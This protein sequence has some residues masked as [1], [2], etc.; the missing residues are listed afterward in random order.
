[1]QSGLRDFNNQSNRKTVFSPVEHEKNQP[2]KHGWCL[3]K[4]GFRKAMRM[5]GGNNLVPWVRALSIHLS[6]EDPGCSDPT[7]VTSFFYYVHLTGTLP[8]FFFF[9]AWNLYLETAQKCCFWLNWAL[10]PQFLSA[11][12]SR[13]L[14]IHLLPSLITKRDT[15]FQHA[16][17]NVSRWLG[18][19]LVLHWP[20]F[21]RYSIITF[22]GN[23][24]LQSFFL[25]RALI[26]SGVDKNTF[27]SLSCW[28]AIVTRCLARWHR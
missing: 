3:R 1:V 22:C 17:R 10:E 4:Y 20:T 21:I 25:D 15:C 18:L 27:C 12:S 6:I 28:M 8:I 14:R 19:Y 24:L 13:I 23:I 7:K 26:L 2:T 5:L 16:F 9:R 11:A